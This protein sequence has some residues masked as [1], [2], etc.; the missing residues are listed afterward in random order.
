MTLL[1]WL[2]LTVVQRSSHWKGL[3]EICSSKILKI[4]EIQLE[5]K[6]PLIPQKELIF[7]QILQTSEMEFS[8][9]WIHS[10]VLSKDFANTA[11]RRCYRKRPSE[12]MQKLWETP[13]SK[14]TYYLETNQLICFPN[15]LTGFYTSFDWR[16]FSN[17][18]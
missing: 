4:H 11:T 15:E 3:F 6:I 13:F 7:L 5:I 1:S 16:V 17:R 2:V 9:K 12:N 10:Q 18:L 14:N 8:L